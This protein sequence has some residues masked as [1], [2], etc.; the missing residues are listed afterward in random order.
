MTVYEK[1]NLELIPAIREIFGD[2]LNRIGA[3]KIR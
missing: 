3:E 2:G 1:R